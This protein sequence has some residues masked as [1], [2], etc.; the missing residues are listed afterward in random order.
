[1]TPEQMELHI[2]FLE[3]CLATERFLNSGRQE[4]YDKWER[5]LRHYASGKGDWNPTVAREALGVCE[6]WDDEFDVI[7]GKRFLRLRRVWR[8]LLEWFCGPCC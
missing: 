8:R 1:V 7:S 3:A 6:Y 5:A 4:T 2:K